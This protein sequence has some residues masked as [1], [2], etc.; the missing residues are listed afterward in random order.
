M[1]TLVRSEPYKLPAG[2]LAVAVHAVF[3]GL[4]YFGFDWQTQPP[5]G[6]VVD[7]WD[8]LPTT[9][10]TADKKTEAPRKV[11]PPKPVETPKVVEPPKPVEQPKPEIALPDKK[12]QPEKPK[13]VVKPEPKPVPK[14]DIQA[15]QQAAA[16]QAAEAAQAAARGRVLDE[17]VGRIRAKIRRNIVMPPDVADDA[18]AIFNVTLLPDGS[19]LVAKLKKSSGNDA[20]DS[21]VERAILKSQPL[22]LPPDV[23]LFNRNFRNLELKFKPKE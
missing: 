20:Y 10:L 19:V 17:Y 8:S 9:K 15:Q 2:L 3:F 5:Q 1:S 13:P 22:P 12:K 11:E 18:L 4:L 14:V 21:A 16:E 7:L 23:T 6:M